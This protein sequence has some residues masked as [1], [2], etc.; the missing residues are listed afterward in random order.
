MAEARAPRLCR[1]YFPQSQ[2]SCQPCGT[3]AKVACSFKNVDQSGRVPSSQR[4]RSE[5][6]SAA[7]AGASGFTL[8]ILK[9]GLFMSL[10][11][12]IVGPTGRVLLV[13]DEELVA[14]IAADSLNELGYEIVEVGTA[15]AALDHAH[16]DCAKFDFA[17]IDLGLPDRTG[18]HLISDL[19]KLC[20][21][22]PIIVASGYGEGE[23]RRKF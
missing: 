23:L 16:L 4:N 5:L 7:P 20:P 6:R 13:E 18:D 9:K 2:R 3:F 12:E 17:V 14:M 8:W 22:L 10:Q 11:L 1:C 15:R 19:R 21:E